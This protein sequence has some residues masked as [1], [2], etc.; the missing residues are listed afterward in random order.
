MHPR[1]IL[2]LGREKCHI[3]WF[4]SIDR[5]SFDLHCP[6]THSLQGSLSLLACWQIGRKRNGLLQV[7]R[8]LVFFPQFA[9]DHSQVVLE[10]GAARLILTAS[11]RRSRANP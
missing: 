1:W 3:P 6:S 7:E 8:R 11:S 5:S 10:R 4:T 9:V 2:A